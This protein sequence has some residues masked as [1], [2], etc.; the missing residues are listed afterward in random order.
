MWNAK[1]KRVI[2]ASRARE[3]GIV[4]HSSVLFLWDRITPF[5][6]EKKVWFRINKPIGERIARALER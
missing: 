1:P 6:D 3:L 4:S 5:S 2:P